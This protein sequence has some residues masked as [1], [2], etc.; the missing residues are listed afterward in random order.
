VTDEWGTLVLAG[1]RC[2]DL[3]SKITNADLSNE[4]FPWL[5][6]KEIEV[7]GVMMRALRINYVGELGWELH[8]PI[9]QL[10][11]VY[12]SVWAVGEEFSIADFGMHALSSLGKEKAYYAWGVELI[13]EITMIEAGMER[14]IDFNKGDFLGREALLQRQKENLKWKIAYVEVDAEDADARGS[15]PV[16]VGDKVIGVTTSGSYGHTVNKSLAFVYVPP[17]FAVPGTT[18]NI[19]ILSHRRQAK[20]LAE[21]AYDPTNKR[22]RS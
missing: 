7:A 21:P 10:E 3:L 16:Y 5:T 17:E 19:E 4:Q 18:F 20:V 12:D 8:M 6:G 15:E 1:P 22:L 11:T 2:R 9:T 14:F 13:N